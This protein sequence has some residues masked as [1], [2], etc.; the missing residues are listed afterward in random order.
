MENGNE[1]ICGNCRE[2]VAG[3]TVRGGPVSWFHYRLSPAPSQHLHES[4]STLAYCPIIFFLMLQ[5]SAQ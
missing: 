1:T 4:Y 3:R 5:G 2:D